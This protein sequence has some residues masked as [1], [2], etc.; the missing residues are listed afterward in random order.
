MRGKLASWLALVGTS[1]VLVVGRTQKY[2]LNGGF[3]TFFESIKTWP[4]GPE[5]SSRKI[6]AKP[7]IQRGVLRA[8]PLLKIQ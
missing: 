7:S 3:A 8:T 4:R 6:V 5:R 2:K 1:V